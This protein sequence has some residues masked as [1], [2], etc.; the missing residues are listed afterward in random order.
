MLFRLFFHASFLKSFGTYDGNENI[1]EKVSPAKDPRLP[2]F[3]TWQSVCPF[4]NFALNWWH[5]EL[6]TFDFELISYFQKHI[7]ILNA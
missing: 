6:L 4:L 1:L 2:C 7:D 5:A 3:L